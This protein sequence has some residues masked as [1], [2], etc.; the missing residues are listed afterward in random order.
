MQFL[1]SV[2]AFANPAGGLLSGV[3]AKTNAK[4]SGFVRLHPR[5]VTPR[6]QMNAGVAAVVAAGSAAVQAAGVASTMPAVT[7][8]GVILLTTCILLGVCGAT[9][10]RLSDGFQNV[11]P[12]ILIFVTYSMSFV[13]FTATLPLWPLSVAYAIWSGVGT[14]LTAIVGVK[15]FKEQ[16][17]PLHYVGFALIITGVCAMSA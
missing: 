2:Q 4:T 13:V 15:V 14:S 1:P 16:L 12:S 11:V 3:S 5:T 7:L 9:C 10:M 6:L 8:K 17:K